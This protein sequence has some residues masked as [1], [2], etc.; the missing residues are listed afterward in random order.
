MDATDKMAVRLL[1]WF[2]NHAKEDGV[3]IYDDNDGVTIGV[4][5]Q[6]NICKVVSYMLHGN[7]THTP[8]PP[9]ELVRPD[10]PPEEAVQAALG[11]LPKTLV[12][13]KPSGD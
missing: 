9:L 3:R 2:R 7:A 10:I 13:D 12:A 5:G 4:D 1:E 11:N 6:I 8:G